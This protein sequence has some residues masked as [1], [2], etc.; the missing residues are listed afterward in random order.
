MRVDVADRC[1]K[2]DTHRLNEIQTCHLQCVHVKCAAVHA[3]SDM[4]AILIFKAVAHLVSTTVQ[5]QILAFAQISNMLAAL[6]FVRKVYSACLNVPSIRQISCKH[7]GLFRFNGKALYQRDAFSILR[8]DF[9]WHSCRK[10]TGDVFSCRDHGT[11]D[12]H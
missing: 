5:A 11:Q 7:T 12:L 1:C 10:D 3:G 4:N 9:I 2:L 8:G 6:L